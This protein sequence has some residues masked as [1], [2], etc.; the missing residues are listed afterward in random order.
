MRTLL[1]FRG[2]PGCGKDL[3]IKMHG[4]SNFSVSA[5]HIKMLCAAPRQ[6][7]S[8]EW[9]YDN[10]NTSEER[11]VMFQILQ[12]RMSNGE[13]TVVD[14][15]NVTTKE[16]NRFVSLAAQYKYKVYMID[17]TNVPI[18]ECKQRNKLS[19]VMDRVPEHVI[20]MAYEKFSKERIPNKIV[21]LN[22]DDFNTIKEKPVDLNIYD[23]V[24]IVGDVH[25][26]YKKL[27]RY[28][29][30]IGGLK[31]NDFYI[32]CGD[33]IDRGPDSDKVVR[34]LISIAALPNVCLLEG[35]HE[36]HLYMWSKDKKSSSEIFEK[37]TRKLLDNSG[38]SKQEVRR[39]YNQLLPCLYFDYKTTA[40]IDSRWIATH[41]G[42]ASPYE[43]EPVGLLGIPT[44]QMIRGVGRY[45]NLDKVAMCWDSKSTFNQV[46][47]HRNTKNFPV[48]MGHKCFVLEGK[49]E[50]GG[51]LRTLNLSH[52]ERP[53]S[54]EV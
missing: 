40:D 54:I 4:L 17:M 51:H 24:H 6:M 26:C 29:E 47:G 2:A 30:L 12:R 41:G 38:L 14:S 8:G 39:F 28:F 52:N 13:F 35:N 9:A 22:P 53:A 3:F 46:F 36:R 27:L 19:N 31:E 7:E 15:T 33:Y 32:F 11:E 50:R 21:A 10:S 42:I 25:G 49:V 1:L 16:M 45:E 48:N 5:N 34:A 37:E 20:D 23:R 44:E 18:E 43:D